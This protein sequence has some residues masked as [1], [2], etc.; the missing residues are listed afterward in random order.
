MNEWI[1]KCV[2]TCLAHVTNS[3][4]ICDRRELCTYHQR[5]SRA[6]HK[7]HPRK[8]NTVD[9]STGNRF[10]VQNHVKKVYMSIKKIEALKKFP[11][12]I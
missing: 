10:T 7:L 12:L 3:G 9:Y 6:H 2:E 4:Q 1:R 8:T 5:F 11:A